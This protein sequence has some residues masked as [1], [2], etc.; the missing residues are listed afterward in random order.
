MLSKKKQKTTKS[1]ESLYHI[2]IVCKHKKSDGLN[3]KLH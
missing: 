3:K 1:T 2:C